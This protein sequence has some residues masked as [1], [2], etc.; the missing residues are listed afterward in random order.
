M[1]FFK[2]CEILEDGDSGGKQEEDGSLVVE[3]KEVR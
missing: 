1:T 2:Y 3:K